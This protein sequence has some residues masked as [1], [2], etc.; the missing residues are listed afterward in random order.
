MKV[1]PPATPWGHMSQ[2]P[3]V[4]ERQNSGGTRHEHH[5]SFTEVMRRFWAELGEPAVRMVYD[6][7]G[8]LIL[9]WVSGMFV[10]LVATQEVADWC[11]TF[12]PEHAYLFAFFYYA[13]GQEG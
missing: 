3:Y 9:G 1:L 4:L 12:A 11:A 5:L 13:N 2:G 7:A 8:V 10:E 6:R